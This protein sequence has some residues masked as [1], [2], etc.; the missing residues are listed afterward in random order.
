MVNILVYQMGKVGSSTLYGSISDKLGRQHSFVCPT[1]NT[2]DDKSNLDIKVYHS[3]RY[4]DFSNSLKKRIPS[5]KNKIL[6][7]VREPIGRNISGFFEDP[8]FRQIVQ[9]NDINNL[10]ETFISRF[11]HQLPLE[12][13]DVELKNNFNIDVYSKPFDVERGYSIY[14][15][16]NNECMVIRVDKMNDLFN[17]VCDF[18]EL[19]NLPRKDYNITGDRSNGNIY[20]LLK[21]NIKLPTN[22]IDK[23]YNS[24]LVKHFFNETE[25]NDL[26]K[27]W[28][29]KEYQ[30]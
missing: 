23:M 21:E 17:T 1:N 3:H 9:L 29:K 22:Y 24:K 30:K 10:T 14:K 16:G 11:N 13:F 19:D 20:K 25:I 8:S 7:L 12:W 4:V 28:I 2:L 5:S 15:N 27:K 26:R 18:L 6:T